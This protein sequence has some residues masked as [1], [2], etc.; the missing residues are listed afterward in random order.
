M[1]SDQGIGRRRFLLLAGGVGAAAA[2]GLGW[3]VVE[4]VRPD[5]VPE[6]VRH[7]ATKIEE[8]FSSPEHVRLVG[9]SYLRTLAPRPSAGELARELVGGSLPSS[10]S[11]RDLER[12]R[13]MMQSAVRKDLDA[14]RLVPVEGWLLAQSEAQLCGLVSLAGS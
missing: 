11:L 10:E 7:L 2:T 12:L 6:S 1:S 13:E 14:G 8:L 3:R 9:D 5:P 4:I